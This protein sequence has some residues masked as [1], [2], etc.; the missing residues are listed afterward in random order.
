MTYETRKRKS[1]IPAAEYDSGSDLDD[2]ESAYA[3]SFYDAVT[4]RGRGRG[5]GRGRPRGRP[6]RTP[7]SEPFNGRTGTTLPTPPPPPLPPTLPPP[8]SAP[9]FVHTSHSSSSVSNT[10]SSPLATPPPPPFLGSSGTGPAA[11]GTSSIPPSPPKTHDLDQSPA[12]VLERDTHSLLEPMCARLGVARSS[13][14][15]RAARIQELKTACDAQTVHYYVFY[16]Y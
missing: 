8:V 12:A 13:P 5:R 11:P 7:V 1:A 2:P 16:F 3:Y 15:D 9:A 10:R 6:P 4:P 14:A